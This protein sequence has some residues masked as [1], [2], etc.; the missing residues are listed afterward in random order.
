MSSTAGRGRE[1]KHRCANTFEVAIVNFNQNEISFTQRTP[2]LR[3]IARI[4]MARRDIQKY[5]IVFENL[6]VFS[7]LWRTIKLDLTLLNKLK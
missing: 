1:R 4:I 6:H 7:R 5:M 3:N 2:M